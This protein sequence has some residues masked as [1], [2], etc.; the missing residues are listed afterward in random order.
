M[1]S[2]F[3]SGVPRETIGKRNPSL[4]VRDDK[5][6]KMCRKAL[7]VSWWMES[8]G[9]SLGQKPLGLWPLWFWPWDFPR[10]SIHHYTPSAFRHIVLLVVWLWASKT[11][12][13]TLKIQLWTWTCVACCFVYTFSSVSMGFLKPWFLQTSYFKSRSLDLTRSD[14]SAGNP[15]YVHTTPEGHIPFGFWSLK[16][17]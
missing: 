2:P 15:E 13:V 7:G 5:R 9:K 4:L 16:S 6:M 12:D 10:D 3:F 14:Y 11:K 8:L 1:P 17:D